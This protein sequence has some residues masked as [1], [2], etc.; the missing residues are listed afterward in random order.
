MK[1]QVRAWLPPLGIQVFSAKGQ[2]LGTIP[3]TPPATSVA[4]AGPDKKTLFILARGA[5][6]K[7]DER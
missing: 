5:E 6:G 7:G 1:P 2:Y 4:F 3:T